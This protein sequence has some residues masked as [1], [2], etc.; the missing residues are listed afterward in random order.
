MNAPAGA[1]HPIRALSMP[2]LAAAVRV[3]A[4]EA[5][6]M[7]DGEVWLRSGAPTI[8]RTTR[9]PLCW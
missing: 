6:V 3:T 9:I 5:R 8:R 4:E 7:R 1:L 2:R